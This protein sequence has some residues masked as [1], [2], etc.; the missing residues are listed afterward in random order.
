MRKV[1]LCVCLRVRDRD[2]LRFHSFSR[3]FHRNAPMPQNINK[4][5][6]VCATAM[7]DDELEYISPAEVKAGLEA[8]A[9]LLVDVRD[10]DR[11]SSGW[12]PGSVW[13]PTTQLRSGNATKNAEFLDNWLRGTLAAG[14]R[15]IVFH[16]QYSQ[17]RGP[18]AAARAMESLKRLTM[19]DVRVSVMTSGFIGWRQCFPAMI[20]R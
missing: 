1:H 13:L 17:M 6:S 20:A 12:V 9:L 11:A 15:H 18:W 8:N 14:P 16:C 10:D 2:G 3:S 7:S 19:R 5:N 4:G